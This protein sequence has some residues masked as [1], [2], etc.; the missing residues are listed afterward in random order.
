MSASAGNPI[1]FVSGGAETG[2]G[3]GSGTGKAG[4]RGRR[5]D[6]APGGTSQFAV[7]GF[8]YLILLKEKGGLQPWNQCSSIDTRFQPDD[9]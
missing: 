6:C 7:L 1:D 3:G 9:G 2:V 8:G 4:A 5:I